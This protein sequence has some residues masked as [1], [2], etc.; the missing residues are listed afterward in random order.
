MAT[1]ASCGKDAPPDSEACP[2]CGAPMRTGGSGGG[3]GG[4]TVPGSPV[5][6]AMAAEPSQT[7]QLPAQNIQIPKIQKIQ[8]IQNIA[9][10]AAGAVV[11]SAARRADQHRKSY[12]AEGA[13]IDHKYAIQRVLGEGGMGVVYLARE[14]HTGVDVVLKAVR[15]ELAHRKDVRERTLAEGRALA[16]IDHPN[17]VHL[18]AVVVEEQALWLVMQ[19]IEGESL[20]KTI[21]RHIAEKRPMLLPEVLR[22]FRQIVA[23]IDAAHQ[24][25]VIHRDLKPA[26]VLIRKKDG[27]AKV[28]DFGIAK[29]EEDARA[30]K[31]MTKGI[32]G[33]LWY[34]SPEQVSGRRDLD[35]RVDIYA[36][37]IVLYELLVGRVPFDADDDHTIM[38]LHLTAPVPLVSRMRRDV[39]ESVDAII[40]KACAKRREDR[41]PACD[42]ILRALDAI[43]A[44]GSGSARGTPSTAPDITA[45]ESAPIPSSAKKKS[46]EPEAPPAPRS[47]APTDAEGMPAVEPPVASTKPTGEPKRRRG[48]LVASVVVVALGGAAVGLIALGVIP[49]LSLKKLRPRTESA[50]NPPGAS[51][52]A[53]AEP[54]T[55]AS[56]TASS[57]PSPAP[58]PAPANPLAALT[59]A[60][61][62]NGRDLEA[63]LS[64]DELEFRVTSPEQFEAQGYDK[65]E[66]R[67]A[68]RQI[69]G[70]TRVFAVEDR[71]R[72]IPP[73]KGYDL[74][75]ARG[76]CLEIW[77]EAGKQPL[78]ATFDGARLTVELAKIEP[79][80]AN[81]TLSREGLVTSCIGLR[82]LRAT[83]VVSSLE[84]KTP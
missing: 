19:Y 42:A 45:P 34:M 80:H 63:V 58:P 55:S 13:V 65:G 66:A 36:L 77:T 74:S 54:P 15:S 39:P 53:P 14:I 29:G 23:G 24:E 30:G 56:P 84:R 76:T 16:R 57:A 59:G 6:E 22:I 75:K 1:C 28:T 71:I 50:V 41:F 9:P 69:P 46:T 49:G 18:K 17:V 60:W 72:P 78:R 35:K 70:E 64:G 32:I 12:V 5:P 61:I 47:I 4:N 11:M 37:G 73:G 44:P 8:N 26:N 51:P 48:W 27:V 40:Q 33:S 2:A 79:T 67:F 52:S 81:F 7:P 82:K 3:G 25:G 83:K 21:K 31:G 20:E 62:G 43:D 38:R 68:L 10:E